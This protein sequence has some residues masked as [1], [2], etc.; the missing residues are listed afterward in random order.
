M[1]YQSS[2]THNS[3]VISKVKVFKKWAKL[4]G[5]GHRVK[6]NGIH[7]KVLS[8]GILMCNIRA[9]AFTVQKLLARLKFQRG[10]QNDRMDKNNMPPDLRSHI[11]KKGPIIFFLRI[12]W[13]LIYSG[14]MFIIYI[15]MI[16]YG[17]V[18]IFQGMLF[19]CYAMNEII[20]K[21]I[22]YGTCILS[23]GMVC[24]GMLCYA[25]LWDLSKWSFF[26]RRVP[27]IC[28]FKALI[29]RFFYVKTHF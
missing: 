2:S 5:Q 18:F 3:K 26:H 19:F 28:H 21:M 12:K 20:Q 8:Q 6:N 17:M 14:A 11:H 7:G 1:K 4:Q 24:Y 25:I 9:L 23:Y 15:P 29:Y 10:G 13:F 27:F 16:W 22:W